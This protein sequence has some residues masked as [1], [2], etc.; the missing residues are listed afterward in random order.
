MSAN[1]VIS[2]AAFLVVGNFATTSALAQI[3]PPRNEQFVGGQTS[4]FLYDNGTGVQQPATVTTSFTLNTVIQLWA[5]RR[6]YEY[7]RAQSDFSSANTQNN[8]YFNDNVNAGEIPSFRYIAINPIAAAPQGIDD[9]GLYVGDGTA[10]LPDLWDGMSLR[11][12]FLNDA[13]QIGLSY[14]AEGRVTLTSSTSGTALQPGV[15]NTFTFSTLGGPLRAMTPV[16]VGGGS[17]PVGS[18]YLQ[19]ISFTTTLVPAPGAAALLG[20]GGLMATRRRR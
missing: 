6:G 3:G 9:A 20:L 2:V 5:S 13:F 11:V 1:P 16:F 15:A 12:D 19:D 18:F 8:P 10:A 14:A 4:S 7:Y 17:P